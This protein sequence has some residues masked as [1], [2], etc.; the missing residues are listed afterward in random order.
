MFLLTGILDHRYNE[1]VRNG[2]FSKD[3]L[4]VLIISWNPAKLRPCMRMRQI[5]FDRKKNAMYWSHCHI[6]TSYTRVGFN[7]SNWFW[8]ASPKEEICFLLSC[9]VVERLSLTCHLPKLLSYTATPW[10]I[11]DLLFLVNGRRALYT[12]TLYS[13]SSYHETIAL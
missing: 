5:T 12:I 3:S 8:H 10:F 2:W 7:G 11:I 9:F 13:G 4:W 1:N 6:N